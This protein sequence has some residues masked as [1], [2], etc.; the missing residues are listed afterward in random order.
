MGRGFGNRAAIYPHQLEPKQ[1]KAVLARVNLPDFGMPLGPPEMSG[2]VY[3]SRLASLIDRVGASGLQILLIYADREHSANL[4][5][6]TGFDPRFEEALLILLPARR[7]AP[8]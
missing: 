4:A 1:M 5:W 3:A 8:G 6:L 7:K 2:R